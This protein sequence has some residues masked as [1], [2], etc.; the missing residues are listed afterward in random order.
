M[1]FKAEATTA[2]GRKCVYKQYMCT[3]SFDTE[4]SIGIHYTVNIT[5][6]TDGGSR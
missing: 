3:F 4:K 2:E 1:Y 6:T 5:L